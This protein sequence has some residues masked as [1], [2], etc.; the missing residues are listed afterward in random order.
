[1]LDFL[2]WSALSF[3]P[4]TLTQYYLDKLVNPDPKKLPDGTYAS[5]NRSS[6]QEPAF[7]QLSLLPFPRK[8]RGI[9][10]ATSG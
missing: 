9:T 1:M 6:R 4:M 3:V 5:A 2:A 7:D 8:R 10:T